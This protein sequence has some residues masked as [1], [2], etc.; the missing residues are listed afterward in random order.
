MEDLCRKVVWAVEQSGRPAGF[1]GESIEAEFAQQPELEKKPGAPSAFVW[2]GQRFEVARVLKE[3]HDYGGS[4]PMGGMVGGGG[5]GAGPWGG[6]S[7]T[8]G[9]D[10]Y[11]VATAG[12]EIFDVYFDRR[13]KGKD[14]KGS[15]TLDRK[16][17]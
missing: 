5:K 2:R 13:P 15:W 14:R 11:R 1:Y 3:W 6:G 9:R 16:I 7:R 17:G 12:G 10:Y 4:G 8:I